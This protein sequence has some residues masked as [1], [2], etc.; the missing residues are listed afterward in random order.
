[1]ALLFPLLIAACTGSE[2]ASSSAA[3]EGTMTAGSNE[4]VFRVLG[5]GPDTAIVIPGGPGL[6]SS[7]LES[8]LEPLARTHTLIFFDPRGRYGAA[9]TGDSTALSIEKD[10]ND[11][12][13]LRLR[14]QLDRM[15]LIGHHYGA[16]V[17]ALYA[18]RF[19]ARVSRML[20][21]APL[22]PRQLY[23]WDLSKTPVD[24]AASQGMLRDMAA[25]LDTADAAGFCRRHWGFHFV[26]APVTD[27]RVIADEA[28]LICGAASARFRDLEQIRRLSIRSLGPRW[29]WRDTLQRLRQPSLI[30]QAQ[31]T[32][33]ADSMEQRRSRM[34][35]HGAETFA[36][37]MP[38]ARI[39]T[40]EA[41][42]WFPWLGDDDIVSAADEFL[43]GEWPRG[44]SRVAAP[45]TPTPVLPAPTD[46]D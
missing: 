1:M 23:V 39:L 16:G 26:P 27:P 18:S 31:V 37:S 34:L 14:F 46:N 36:G 5:N 38:E 20:L 11:V 4:I 43:R 2:R 29:D 7:Y 35:L 12:N 19:P 32:G 21:L 24:S 40:V 22:Y 9:G 30:V 44:A 3:T 25:G 6:G 41:P 8:A 10:L 17:A 28:P 33:R 45:A 13:V 42:L 15:A